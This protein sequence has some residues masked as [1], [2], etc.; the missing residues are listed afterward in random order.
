MTGLGL[1]L[2]LA[3]R[4]VRGSWRSL[5]LLVAAVAVGVASLVAIR[6]FSDATLRAVRSEARALLGADLVAGSA[7]PFSAAA[8][9]RLA[10]LLQEAGPHRIARVTSFGA[11]AVAG[12]AGATRLVQVLAVEDGYPFYGTI[13]TTPTGAWAE[14]GRARRAL[15]DPGVLVALGV[16]PGQSL[17]IGDARFEIAG[18]VE[19][20]PGDIGVRSALGP[21]VFIPRRFVSE[22]RLLGFGSRVRHEA[23]I[24]LPAGVPAPLLLRHRAPLAAQRVNLRTVDE[25][26]QRLGDGLLRLG[27]FL[28]LVGLVALLLGGLGVASAV[29]V[30]LQR[31]ADSIA[32]LRSLGA[33]AAQVG[34][35]Y[36]AQALGLGLLGG[37]LGGVLGLGLASVLPRVLGDLL[38]VAV[39]SAPS[40]PA[41]FAGIGLGAACAVLF[42]LPPLLGIRRVSPMA[43]LRRDV[44]PPAARKDAW[45]RAAL[46]A[47]AAG[48]V[49]LSI[50]QAGS[51]A[52]GLIFAAGLG[53]C[54][55]ALALTAAALRSIVRR[56]L[57]PALSYVWRQG[58]AALHRPANQTRA[59]V[60]SIGF[61]V[62]LL[63][64]LLV[65]QANL[66]RD[67]RLDAG[68]RRPNL[69]LFDIQPDQVAGVLALVR[70]A[71]GEAGSAT[72]IVP[73]RIASVKGRP[74]SESLGQLGPDGRPAE[75]AWALRREYRSSYRDTLGPAETLVAG[76]HWMPGEWMSAREGPVPVSLDAGLAAELG[77]GVGDEITWDV[78]GVL[79]ASRVAS[80]RRIRWARFEPNFFA[81]FPE[82]PLG[83]AP[84]SYVSLTRIG[85]APA[86]ARLERR[87]VAAFPNLSA[88]DLADLE[89]SLDALFGRVA[90]AVR[91]MALF[92]GAVGLLVLLGAVATSQRQRLREAVLL[93][94]LG[95]TRSQV[96]RIVL[97]EYVCLGG[98]AALA[99]ILLG[100]VAGG[101]LLRFVFETG[102]EAPLAALGLLFALVVA[103]TAGLGVLLGGSV[104]RHTSLELLR[105]E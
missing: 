36:L 71:G 8:E 91:F 30:L 96:R 23:F 64:I 59:V 95:A 99:G 93:K 13:E 68:P 32:I 21:R 53:A 15:V 75:N 57:S 38:P 19:R 48:L 29:R 98:L 56:A 61:G 90:W 105:S 88:L 74:A 28:G 22:T 101:A 11:M 77:V 85:S 20:F 40:W 103:A 39:D 69:A 49:A 58:L 1:V 37:V 42:A 51:P 14:L 81:I 35:V 72:P 76:R 47:P 89:R 17:A 31:R 18:V 97:A 66:L 80:L 86:R 63:A 2:A 65:L 46:V 50:V 83:R 78:Q 5:T 10:T 12:E 87:A 52:L 7:A 67:L 26:Q 94:A 54:L 16:G 27:R 4:E 70:E 34:A 24:A 60:S 33:T 43:A 3:R 9:A 44:E 102:F 100:L 104:F 41:L 25:D 92:S 79:L 84:R 6:S 73:M 82:G 45:D 55:A 62:F